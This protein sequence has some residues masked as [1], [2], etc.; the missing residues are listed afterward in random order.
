MRV[1][2]LAA[3]VFVLVA[4]GDG[5]GRGTDRAARLH[6]T[7]QAGAWRETALPL[8]AGVRV[9]SLRLVSCPSAG[10][11]SAAGGYTDS[12]GHQQGLSVTE[13]NGRW[14]RRPPPA[15]RR[16]RARSPTASLP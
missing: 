16:M 12:A 10:N 13:S 2:L 1:A 15:S 8:P 7:Q 6:L 3:A 11:C 5:A 4:G 14:G 9:G